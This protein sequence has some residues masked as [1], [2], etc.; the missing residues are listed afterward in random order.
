MKA[1]FSGLAVLSILAL[2]TG[3]AYDRLAVSSIDGFGD[4]ENVQVHV[5][6]DDRALVGR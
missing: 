3:F 6:A 2:I 1:F 5:E 4:R